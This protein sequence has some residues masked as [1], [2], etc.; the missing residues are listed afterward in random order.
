MLS[1]MAAALVEIPK[2]VILVANDPVGFLTGIKDLAECLS[3]DPVLLADLIASLPDSVI[4]MQEQ[5]NPYKTNPGLHDRYAEG[6]YTGYIGS[7]II[8][9]FVGGGE[10]KAVK[11]SDDFARLSKS[12]PSKMGDIKAYLKISKSFRITEKFGAFLLDDTASHGLRNSGKVIAETETVG[13]Q[14]SKVKNFKDIGKDKIETLDDAQQKELNDILD[15]TG[16][17]GAR[18][19]KNIDEATRKKILSLK[20]LKGVDPGLMDMLRANLAELCDD[21]IA[22]PEEIDTFITNIEKLEGAKGLGAKDDIIHRA[23]MAK[24]KINFKGVAF[25]AKTVAKLADSKGVSNIELG[26]RPTGLHDDEKP[27]DIDIIINDN[28]KK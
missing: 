15:R 10:L 12:V 20:D 4:A 24:S 3:S 14:A 5:E 11:S 18:S 26:R 17:D 13:K 23:S 25:E 19:I 22:T 2:L 28:G 7:Q 8:S 6:W 27:G 1:G 9:L 21:G 16:D